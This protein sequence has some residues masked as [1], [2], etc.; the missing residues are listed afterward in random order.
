MVNYIKKNSIVIGYILT[1]I[2]DT[3][4]KFSED[5]TNNQLLW[6]KAIGAVVAVISTQYQAILNEKL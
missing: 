3:T 5:L 4:F 6:L 2:S 1:I